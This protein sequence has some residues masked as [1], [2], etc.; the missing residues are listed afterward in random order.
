M[1][2]L[3]IKYG[4]TTADSVSIKTDLLVVG[5]N[6]GSKLSKAQ[7]LG[8]KIISEI[9]FWDLIKTSSD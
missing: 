9:E 3:A 4:A 1:M 8:I 2:E 6:A 5:E 7:S